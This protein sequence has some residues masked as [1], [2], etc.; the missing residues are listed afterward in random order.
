M[1][2]IKKVIQANNEQF[3]G[4]WTLYCTPLKDGQKF[5]GKLFISNTHLY[6]EFQFNS[7]LSVLLSS[8]SANMMLS[9]GNSLM[10][11][12]QILEHWRDNG[13]LTISKSD[14]INIS[15]KKSFLKKTLII[16]LSDGSQYVFDNGILPISRIIQAI[17]IKQKL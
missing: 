15:E 9:S 17:Q 8:I 10:L 1:S 7:S 14:I 2:V 5:L 11:S 16:R 13:Y 12:H 3:L 4:R 6:F